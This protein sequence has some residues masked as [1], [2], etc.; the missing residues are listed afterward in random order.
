M[1]Y[2]RLPV[3][4]CCVLSVV[5][6]TVYAQDLSGVKSQLNAMFSGLDTTKI[7]THRLWDR[8]A[9]LVNGEDFN[10]STLTDSNYVDLPRLYDMI[11]SINSASVGADTIPA[12]RAIARIQN[13]SSGQSTVVGVLFKP[14]NY[15]VANALQDNLITYSNQIVSDKYIN[16][17]WQNPYGE[18]VLVGHAVGNEGVVY[19]STS[20][21]L[22]NVDSLSTQTFTS[23]QF[24]AG[25]GYGFRNISFGTPVIVTYTDTS[26]HE[27]KLKLV[28]NGITY[29]SHSIVYVIPTPSQSQPHPSS[30]T[31]S[32]TYSSYDVDTTYLGRT[33]Y[34]KVIYDQSASFNNPL[35][36]AEG[37]DP[38]KLGGYNLI[39]DYSGSTDF[40]DINGE[41]IFSGLDVFYIDWYDCG[42]DI[43]ANAALLEK[44]ILWVNQQ[45][46][47]HSMSPKQ[48][49]VL[50]QS[51]GGL[52]AR[53]CLCSMEERGVP[54]DTR[55]FISHDAPHL[56]ANV[57]P[58]LQYLY[59]DLCNH[60]LFFAPLSIAFNVQDAFYELLRF[61]KY[62][63]VRQMLPVY[64][65]SSGV[66]DNSEYLSFQTELNNL[67]F[68]RG[69]SGKTIENVAIV[70]GGRA[71]D[72]SPSPYKP[73]NKLLSAHLNASSKAVGE[74]I[75]SVLSLGG[76]MLWVPGR[77][78]LTISCDVYPFLS[79]SSLARELVVE[80]TK[81]FLWIL[82]ITFE[83]AHKRGYTPSYGTTCFDNVYN[84]YYKSP[85]DSTSFSGESLPE[86]WSFLASL[87]YDLTYR[88]SLSF[89]PTASALCYTDSYDRDFYGSPV[90]PK[91]DIPFDSYILEDYRSKHISF[92]SGLNNWLPEVLSEVH[93]PPVVFDG[94][95][96][97]ITGAS[98]PFTWTSSNSSVATVDGSLV[99]RVSD[100]LVEFTA[101]TSN[102]GWAITKT[103]KA[104]MGF[105]AV[106]LSSEVSGYGYHTISVTYPTPEKE[107]IIKDAVSQGILQYH[108]GV[109]VGSDTSIVW[110]NNASA[111]DTIHVCIPDSLDN[112]SV[113]M[114]WIH[115]VI[116]EKPLRWTP[117]CRPNIYYSSID[118]IHGDPVN[119]ITIT[120]NPVFSFPSITATYGH[121]CLIMS[122]VQSANLTPITSITIEGEIFPVAGVHYLPAYGSTAV[123]Y[124]FDIFHTLDF[125]Q[126][127]VIPPPLP[128][129]YIK[130]FNVTL[131]GSNGPIQSVVIP[132][133]WNRIPLPI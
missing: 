126:M 6:S 84:S 76:Q 33:Y 66:Y 78:N 15:I 58:G 102:S 112:V 124:V 117:V 111:I 42:A 4:L 8:A 37:F 91:I 53:Y 48:N 122:C 104:I 113:Y 63:S 54:H 16:G 132:Y 83:L 72:G 1:K 20:F 67:G 26:Y 90:L 10:G 82:P 25:D 81:K 128:F 120:E 123:L 40:E 29:L 5:S 45:K 115:G 89:I 95:T 85:E 98:I 22:Q 97:R 119:G 27:T 36:V 70:N 19:Q 23:I 9:N 103:R 50:G 57:S 94:D 41:S 77:T 52:I 108:W 65:N 60:S 101:S 38:W 2:N 88:D 3:L 64:L 96:L 46:R 92:Y 109:K 31:T 62:T 87:H 32:S 24:D 114:K 21:T 30:N 18:A 71:S 99:H 28:T 106:T 12:N 74:F 14:Y 56:G 7:A 11:Y 127:L 51:M 68:P 61:G 86:P 13:L 47:I 131:N 43:R 79:N 116:E 133:Y 69:D 130:N 39:H 107:Q 59:W 118:N 75:L 73:G 35:I 93:V 55:M 34:A 129:S 80:Y 105:P 49:V 100:G 44:V 110:R 17:I 121:Y 125:Q